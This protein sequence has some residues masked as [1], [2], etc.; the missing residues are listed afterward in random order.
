MIPESNEVRAEYE[1]RFRFPRPNLE[2]IRDWVDDL[3]TDKAVKYYLAALLVLLALQTVG[4][5]I[6]K[7][8]G[9][10]R[11]TTEEDK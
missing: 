3:D 2:P 1:R 11:R 5:A 7:I 10:T 4:S 9:G 6:A 8:V